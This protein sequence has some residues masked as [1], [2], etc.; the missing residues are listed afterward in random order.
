MKLF[1]INASFVNFVSIPSM[2]L[3]YIGTYVRQHSDCE[4]EIIEPSLQELDR[5]AVL[6]KVV[7]AEG[8][9][10]VGLV[11][12]TESRFDVFEFAQD[13]SKS[14]PDAKII[15]GGV[16]TDSLHTLAMQQY[17]FVDF[18]A[19][20]EAED[21]VLEV[22]KGKALESIKGLTWR[23]GAEIAV[24]PERELRDELDALKYDY[25][26]VE[27]WITRWKDLEIP[28]KY[29]TLVHIPIIV[30]RGCKFKCSFCGA[31]DFWRDRYR[32]VSNVEII[33]RMK[34]LIAKYNVG[35]FRFYDALF[36][37]N[38]EKR[39]L[40]FC[41]LI[42]ENGIKVNFRVDLRVGTSE[43]SLAALR[44]AGCTVIGFGIES[45]SDKVLKKIN[46]AITNKMIRQTCAV[47]RKLGFWTIGFFMISMPSEEL[48]DVKENFRIFNL[49]DELNLQFFK[50]HPGTPFY[51]ELKD[52]GEIND[53]V[54]FDI[55]KADS[56]YFY[57]SELFKSAKLSRKTVEFMLLKYYMLPMKLKHY[58]GVALIH[59][60]KTAKKVLGF[61]RL[62]F[63]GK[64]S[65]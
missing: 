38:E 29:Q 37:G 17:P 21:T 57:C 31:S 49:F 18:I 10:I 39:I 34:E 35:Y 26:L 1:L 19:R 63:I 51:R 25:T 40:D 2:G 44:E 53:E 14:R 58:L 61:I 8:E 9:L 23:K 47:T 59:P 52:N 64:V 5:A 41:R 56:E 32:V 27:P 28:A 42:K 12:Y 13:V 55:S 50:I 48:E 43:A 15:I 45:A 7:A 11:C 36:L 30:S 24:N 6:R 60:V 3:G 4:V 20:G 16:H 62:P 65:K 46:K 22:I 33:R 54:W